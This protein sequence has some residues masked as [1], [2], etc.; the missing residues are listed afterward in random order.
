[1]REPADAHQPAAAA[2]TC[3][4]ACDAAISGLLELRVRCRA[5]DIVDGW[6]QRCFS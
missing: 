1:M 5:V 6:R 2:A 4:E 3:F